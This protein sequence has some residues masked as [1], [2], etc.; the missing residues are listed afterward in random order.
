MAA[1]TDLVRT[2]FMVPADLLKDFQDLAKQRDQTVSQLIR[3][4]MRDTVA[5]EEKAA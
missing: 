5:S 3:Q 4:F 2:S 1:D